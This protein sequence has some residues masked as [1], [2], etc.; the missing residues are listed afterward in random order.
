MTKIKICGITNYDD[1]KAALDLGVDALGF[2]FYPGSPRCIAITDAQVIVR[3]LPP[4]A[5]YVGV[6]VNQPRVEVERIARSVALDTLQ[7]HGDETAEYCG[8]WPEWRVI[9]ALRVKPTDR[10]TELQELLQPYL[11]VVDHLLIDAFHPESF[12]GTGLTV[13]EEALDTIAATSKQS[14]LQNAFLA[15]GLTPENVAER[16][17]RFRPWGVDVASGVES[18]PGRKDHN[19]LKLFVRQARSTN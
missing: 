5:W 19:Q 16:V 9:K 1:A 14:L 6:F 17:K 18:G 8:S 3:R 13:G 15:G 11:S 2:N 10:V 4:T 12:G 7:F